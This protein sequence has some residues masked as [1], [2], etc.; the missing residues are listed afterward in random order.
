VINIVKAPAR[1]G[2][3]NTNKNAVT[4]IDHTN[5]GAPMRV[6][7]TGRIF[8]IV[9]MKLIAPNRDDAPE[10]CKLKIARSTAGP[11]WARIPDN[12]G[13]KVHPVPAPTSTRDELS[14]KTS[15]GG[16]NQK[17]K[18][19]NRGNAMSGAPTITGTNQLPNPPIKTGITMKK[20]ITTAWAVTTTLYN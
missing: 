6:N 8:M 20:I 2:N 10:R 5:R 3:D 19:F 17:L 15:D 12:G 14:N 11:P 13:Y 9:T 1:T 18:L 4:K 7:P 16:S